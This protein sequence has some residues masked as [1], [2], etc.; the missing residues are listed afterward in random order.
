MKIY[1]RIPIFL[2]LALAAFLVLEKP[3]WADSPIFWGAF[4]SMA[5]IFLGAATKGVAFI[6]VILIETVVLK[7]I[8]MLSWI[9]AFWVSFALN[10]ISSL[11]GAFIGT[12]I[13]A[14]PLCAIITLPLFIIIAVLISS[15]SKFPWWLKTIF[16][17][18]LLIG[19]IG[20]GFNQQIEMPVRFW[21]VLFALL[22]PLLFGFGLTLLIEG[23]VSGIFAQGQTRWR[24]VI[25]ANLY[26]YI[27]LF[28]M[29][30]FFA[31][32][33]YANSE[34][35]LSF[36]VRH[37]IEE[38]GDPMAA[39]PIIHTIRATNLQLL[40]LA[41]R[42]LI[43]RKY[44]ASYEIDLIN[45]MYI[46]GPN[47]KSKPVIGQVIIEDTFAVPNLQSGTREKLEWYKAFLTYW[48]KAY[49][50]ISENNQEELLQVYDSW[51]KWDKANPSPV[52]MFVENAKPG[53]VISRIIDGLKSELKA[54]G[55][56]AGDETSK[57]L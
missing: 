9:Y 27:F 48:G 22:G 44:D 19:L 15:R 23:W 20:I 4:G 24:G 33:P 8:W 17:F 46:E 43:P 52:I 2:S 6:V 31:P 5:P 45:A 51:V 13:F 41:N 30:P 50:A 49:N 47:Y 39:L 40:E 35:Y 7:R 16:G 11:A 36:K 37:T 54:P 53:Y 12:T 38:K 55:K 34:K 57:G 26:S 32:N 1:P 21:V 28:L 42:D 3:A 56:E 10:F 18:A 14:V 29:M 25:Y